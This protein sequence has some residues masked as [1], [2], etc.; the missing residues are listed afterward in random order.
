M[1][2]KKEWNSPEVTAALYSNLAAGNCLGPSPPSSSAQIPSGVILLQSLGRL[3]EG[4][5]TPER[6]RDFGVSSTPQVLY[7]DLV[8]D[9]EHIW[10]FRDQTHCFLPKQFTF[11]NGW[12]G[13][14]FMHGNSPGLWCFLLQTDFCSRD[15]LTWYNYHQKEIAWIKNGYFYAFGFAFSNIQVD[16]SKVGNEHCRR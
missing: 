1:S 10:R 2:L 3:W 12:S 14:K 7:Y 13:R 11:E 9:L 6:D 8:L 15:F 16:I 5:H 4:L